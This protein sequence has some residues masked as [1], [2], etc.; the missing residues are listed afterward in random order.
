MADSRL[1]IGVPKEIM[2]HELRVAAIP[3]TV[4][5]LVAAGARVL[6]ESG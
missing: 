5:K 6:V 1:T 4:K 2:E 3:A